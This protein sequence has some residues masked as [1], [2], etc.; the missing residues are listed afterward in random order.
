[1]GGLIATP[2][3]TGVA[4]QFAQ[5]RRSPA[6]RARLGSRGR[7][8]SR[9]TGLTLSVGSRA[10][11][12]DRSSRGSAANGPVAF[13][14][15]S[16][17]SSPS[18]LALLVP[19][20]ASCCHRGRHELSSTLRKKKKG[21]GDSLATSRSSCATSGRD[22]NVRGASTPHAL[23]SP[24]PRPQ[25]CP[26]W[27]LLNPF[28]RP[29]HVPQHAARP[30]V[31]PP[32]ASFQR[33]RLFARANRNPPCNSSMAAATQL[34]PSTTQQQANLKSAFSPYTDSPSS[35]AP[36]SPHFRNSNR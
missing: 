20:P 10:Q 34:M 28:N 14:D 24:Q 2:V 15:A 13:D 4:E 3:L 21:R 12:I 7:S 8:A 33:R 23:T 6:R 27:P 11:P 19:P 29:P 35:P 17:S 26:A 25:T 5:Q 31:Q 16:E 22:T 36:F 30:P 32:R 9:R 18:C 1:M